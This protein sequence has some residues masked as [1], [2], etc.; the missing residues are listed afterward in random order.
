MA[1]LPEWLCFEHPILRAARL[2]INLGALGSRDGVGG[3]RAEDG[4]G[5]EEE[6]GGEAVAIM[7]VA[8]T[9]WG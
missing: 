9:R 1:H 3:R 6:R 7:A 8:L 4:D 2:P 5:E